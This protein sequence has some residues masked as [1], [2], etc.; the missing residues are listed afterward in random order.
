[1]ILLTLSYEFIWIVLKKPSLGKLLKCPKLMWWKLGERSFPLAWMHQNIEFLTAFCIPSCEQSCD[2]PYSRREAAWATFVSNAV[3]G[4]YGMGSDT[5]WLF[6]SR[7]CRA[8]WEGFAADSV[9]KR[10]VS[11]LVPL[12]RASMISSM[13]P[14]QRETRFIFKDNICMK[15]LR[16]YLF[17]YSYVV[18][19]YDHLCIFP[20]INRSSCLFCL[21]IHLLMHLSMQL[22]IYLI[23]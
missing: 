2:L 1:M 16:I 12:Q 15:L 10:S 8:S 11:H 13:P 17:M 3:L 23:Q 14:A 7:F 18:V 6:C 5:S 19:I 9:G 4:C 21:F 22:F 20:F